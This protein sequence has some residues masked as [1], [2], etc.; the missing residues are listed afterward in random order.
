M[1]WSALLLLVGLSG[2][3]T[4][5]GFAEDAW[6][7][8][9]EKNNTNTFVVFA[10]SNIVIAVHGTQE[11]WTVSEEQS[12]GLFVSRNGV[13]NE[14]FI[15]TKFNERVFRLGDRHWMLQREGS[16]SPPVT[17]PGGWNQPFKME[18]RK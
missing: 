16:A 15:A 2:V 4:P 13:T 11:V 6:G 12:N 1:K 18:D 17:P 9:I 3:L 14:V 8:W 5:Y 10:P 7:K